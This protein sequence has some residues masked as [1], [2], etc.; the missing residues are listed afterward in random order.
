[1]SGP[2]WPGQEVT[3]VPSSPVSASPMLPTLRPVISLPPDPQES[4]LKQLQ[5]QKAQQDIAQGGNTPEPLGAGDP[6]AHE[7]L[8][9]TGLS[10]PAFYVLTGQSSSLP[11]DAATRNIAFK[12]AE[13]FAKT[14]GVDIS[15]L[16][17]QYQAYNQT[18]RSNIMRNNQTNILEQE[19]AG[20][21]D[22]LKPIADQAGMGSLNIVNVGKLFAGK[23]FNDPTVQKYRQQLLILQSELAG[24]NAAARGNI[25]QSGNVK[26]DQG[27]MADA[28]QVIM[29]GLNSGGAEGLKQAVQDTTTKNRAVLQTNIDA[30][31]RAIWGLFG[32]GDHYQ[33]IYSTSAPGQ[34][35][36]QQQNSASGVP[37]VGLAG[38]GSNGGSGPGNG[39]ANSPTNQDIYGSGPLQWGDPA[40]GAFDRNAYLQK[41]YGIDSGTEAKIVG[42]WNANLDNRN[43]TPDAVKQWYAGQGLSPPTDDFIRQG[44]QNAQ[45]GVPFQGVDTTQAEKQYTDQLDA[46]IKARGDNPESFGETA[47]TNLAQ[48]ITLNG[49]DELAG[50]GGAV[51]ALAQGNNPV[52]GYQAERDIQRREQDRSEAAHPVAAPVF[53]VAGGLLTAP[54][55][56]GD[57]NT[58]ADAVK[59]GAALGGVAGFN[60]GNGAV[61]SLTQ[62]VIGAGLGAGLTVAGDAA[63][64]GLAARAARKTADAVPSAGADT[65]AAADRLNTQ[66]GTN[67]QPTPADVSGPGIRNITGGAAKFP[68]SAQPIIAGAKKVTAE[69]QKARDAIAATIGDAAATPDAAG[70]TALNGALSYIKNSKTKV[71]ALYTKARQL[72]GDTPVDLANARAA[73]DQNIAELSQ[74]P[75]GAPALD[76]LKALRAELDQPYPVEGVR[77]MRTVLRDRFMGDGL[78]STDVE[79]RVGQ[80]V[81]AAQ[82]DVVNSLD[83]AGK[84]DAAQA[85]AAAANA[86]AARVGV[87]DNV[88][89]PIIGKN[90]EKSAEQ[91]FQALSGASKTKGAQ[92]GK[93][94]NALPKDDAATVR[95]SLIGRLGQSPAGQ[96]NAA[97]DVF[98]LPAF[99]THWNQMSETAKGQLFGGETRSALNDLAQVAEGTK[100]AQK[101]ANVSNTGGVIGI[102]TTLA[103]A[104]GALT[105]PMA[106]AT[107]LL[108]QYGGGRLL[109]SPRFARW[110]VKMP[111]DP[112]AAAAH[113]R[114]LAKIATADATIA[115]DILGLQ[116][117]LVEAFAPSRL[118]AQPSNGTSTTGSGTR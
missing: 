90:G 106:V 4:Q 32:V 29:N 74:T 1:M 33:P 69:A 110:L 18:L 38:G 48:G 43:L 25:D 34:Q 84:D 113:V 16:G 61:D 36:S 65:M 72:G 53:N 64:S 39:S 3:S 94:L 10:V 26:T 5:I 21:I 68:A 100:E 92:L 37:G 107:S 22:V 76:Q 115:P 58:V 95:A 9:Q 71:D 31:R 114:S 78:R 40:T 88:L 97:G 52:A 108:A 47:G 41:T 13:Q 19:I 91:V 89:Q 99:L 103:Q 96:Q 102:G 67:I 51:R 66:F 59:A 87:I 98:S 14:H 57:A 62:G 42:F 24:M 55:A 50:V 109:A 2:A 73:L 77:N 27:D 79:R 12:Q 46:A 83:A 35:S 15:S 117:K 60:S 20:T 93:F 6:A 45:K 118:A 104:G 80:V 7:L 17:D 30:T 11:R 111:K 44:I 85:Y 49:L 8:G 116:Q 56:F 70:E 105:S 86:H 82:Q 23:Q 112:A 75:G 101:F 28:A 81:D 63:A 54:I